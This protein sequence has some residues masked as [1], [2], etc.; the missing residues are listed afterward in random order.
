M[1]KKNYIIILVLTLILLTACAGQTNNDIRIERFRTDPNEKVFTDENNEKYYFYSRLEYRKKI[2][3]DTVV[4]DEDEDSALFKKE[5][6]Y[7]SEKKEIAIKEQVSEKY[8]KKLGENVEIKNA[9]VETINKTLDELLNIKSSAEAKRY[10]EENHLVTETQYIKHG[11]ST[12]EEVYFYE[13]I[14]KD[15]PEG[16]YCI[17]LTVY[18]NK[19]LARQLVKK[20]NGEFELTEQ[21]CFYAFD[22]EK[23][24]VNTNQFAI[25]Y[26]KNLNEE[27]NVF[28]ELKDPF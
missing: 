21:E 4:T 3:N 10:C 28:K 7:K 24:T 14:G 8:Y 6:L 17:G 16:Y 25:W 12:N 26:K 13:T 27:W 20:E 11:D 9:E 22:V 23:D 2:D 5:Y 18:Y 15:A 19:Y 1:R